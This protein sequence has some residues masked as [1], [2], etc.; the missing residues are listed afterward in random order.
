[1]TPKRA[2]PLFG[3]ALDMETH[4]FRIIYNTFRPHQA[5]ADKTPKQ[6][7]LDDKTPPKTCQLLDARQRITDR[8]SGYPQAVSGQLDQHRRVI[9]RRLALAF[10][11]DD[12]GVRDALGQCR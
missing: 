5:L 2:L 6:A 9:T 3:D 10:L 8:E 4:H 7:Y 11:A 12:L 1:L